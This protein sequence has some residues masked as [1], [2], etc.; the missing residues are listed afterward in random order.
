[1]AMKQS[2]QP[3]TLAEVELVRLIAKAP[4]PHKGPDQPALYLLEALHMERNNTPFAM[5]RYR[6]L[7]SQ[8]LEGVPHPYIMTAYLRLSDL[9]ER[10][11]SL[12]A[13]LGVVDE[14]MTVEKGR[15][16][17]QKPGQRKIMAHR[18]ARLV[19]LLNLQAG[20]VQPPLL[21]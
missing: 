20:A 7:I 17:Q 11:G 15:Q 4:T 14:F 6:L 10:T 5:S 2:V 9:L 21:M 3:L 16:G 19:K 18:R 12:P 1:M 13:A 8:A